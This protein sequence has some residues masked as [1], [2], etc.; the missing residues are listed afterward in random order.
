MSGGVISVQEVVV[1]L[2]R[3]RTENCGDDSHHFFGQLL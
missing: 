2:V 3:L 1:F